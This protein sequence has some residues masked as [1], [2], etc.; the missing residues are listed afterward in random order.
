M[1][2]QIIMRKLLKTELDFKNPIGKPDIDTHKI[3]IDDHIDHIGGV[4]VVIMPYNIFCCN[5]H[6]ERMKARSWLKDYVQHKSSCTGDKKCT[7]GLHEAMTRG[8]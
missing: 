8:H 6:Q 1:I 4:C 5:N 3:D 7:C 2:D